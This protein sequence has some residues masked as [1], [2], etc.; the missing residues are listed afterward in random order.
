MKSKLTGV[1]ATLAFF[2]TVSPAS[3]DIVHVTYTGVVRDGYDQTGVFG[4]ANTSLA[5]QPYIAAYTFDTSIGQTFSSPTYNYAVGGYISAT[6]QPS[7]SLG[8][9]VIINNHT[10]TIGGAAF[11]QLYGL[12]GGGGTTTVYDDARDYF[13][14]NADLHLYNILNNGIQLSDPLLP[15]SIT[16]PY[17]YTVPHGDGGFGLVVIQ[18]H[19]NQ[20]GDLIYANANLLPETVTVTDTSVS[21]PTPIA[22][23]GL[24]GMLLAV[25]GLFGWWR[26]CQ[27]TAL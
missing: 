26:R 7:P 11:G 4:P 16:T 27:R 18:T 6:F 10:V 5:G 14:F 13:V 23:A 21:V 25:G 1:A 9:F 22:G 8:A 24:P 2:G 19:S 15:T 20:Y 17:I 3:S 12:G